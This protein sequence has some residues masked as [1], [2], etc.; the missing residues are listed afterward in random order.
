MI[1]QIQIVKVMSLAV[2]RLVVTVQRIYPP[3]MDHVNAAMKLVK[4]ELD[5]HQKYT[6]F[7]NKQLEISNQTLNRKK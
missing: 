6:N 1:N 4:L 3:R 2:K 7:F 5:E